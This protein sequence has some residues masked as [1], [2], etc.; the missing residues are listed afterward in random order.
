MEERF[1]ATRRTL[2]DR[3]RNVDDYAGWREFFENYW[4]L[5]YA[6]ARRSGLDEFEA[7]EVVQET[8]ITAARKIPEFRYDPAVGSFRA[9][10]LRSR[11]GESLINSEN[12]RSNRSAPSQ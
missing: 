1:L 6:V 12:G 2:L 5:I 8:V 9:G 3:L 11:A 7:E 4:R 10:L